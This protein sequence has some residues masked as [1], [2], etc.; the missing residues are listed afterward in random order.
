MHNSRLKLQNHRGNIT[1]QDLIKTNI[2]LYGEYKHCQTEN[3][4]YRVTFAQISTNSHVS[5][6]FFSM[7]AE[8]RNLASDLT[9][10]K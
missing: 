8:R 9:M 5:I 6:D 4:S 10:D 7:T 3:S 2:N 1:K